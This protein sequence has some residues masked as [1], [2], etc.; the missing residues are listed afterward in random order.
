MK[1]YTKTGDA[2]ETALIGGGRVSK[3]NIRVAAYGDIDELNAALGTV[4]ALIHSWHDLREEIEMIQRMLFGIGAEMATPVDRL[5][6]HSKGSLEESDVLAL[7]TSIDKKEE[8]LPALKTFI[9]P[10]GGHAGAALHMARTVCRR[11][12]RSA[13]SVHA[14]EPVRSEILLYLN[15]LSDWLFVVARYVNHRERH[16]EVPW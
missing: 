8:T 6:D 15:R 13:I 11:A 7:E 9:L 14:E 10:G 16:S 12:E 4:H 5:K 1:I 2:G 3:D